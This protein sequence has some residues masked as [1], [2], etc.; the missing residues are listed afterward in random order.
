MLQN[1]KKIKLSFGK[2][3][4]HI[5]ICIN[6]EPVFG[7]SIFDKFDGQDD[8][9]SIIVNKKMF[10]LMSKVKVDASIEKRNIWI[11]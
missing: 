6:F 3:F 4:N 7:Q 5:I 10:D 11:W 2:S 9:T 1:I 8:I